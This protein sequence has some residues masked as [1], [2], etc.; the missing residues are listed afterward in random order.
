[1]SD[2]VPQ[3]NRQFAVVIQRSSLRNRQL[4]LRL[5][6]VFDARSLGMPNLNRSGPNHSNTPR[7][8]TK[9]TP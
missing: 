7:S 9:K 4:L 3:R 6:T 2:A 8:T 5:L 1:M